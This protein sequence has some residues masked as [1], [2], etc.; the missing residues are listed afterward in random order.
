MHTLRVARDSAEIRLP[1]APGKGQ[2]NG[3][4]IGGGERSQ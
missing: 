3:K 4:P 1:G 2:P